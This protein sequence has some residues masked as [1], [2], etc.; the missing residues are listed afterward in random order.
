MRVVSAEAGFLALGAFVEG[1]VVS[2]IAD[3]GFDATVIPYGFNSR[4][5]LGTSTE[6]VS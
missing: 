1:F 2:S 5:R 6:V 3:T 4:E